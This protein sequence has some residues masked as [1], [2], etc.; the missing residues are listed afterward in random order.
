MSYIRAEDVLPP[1]VLAL[2]QTYI[3]G[4]MLY[5]PKKQSDRSNWGSVSGTKEYYA[6][7]NAEICA[8]AMCG[9]RVCE[10]ADQYGLTPKSIQRILRGSR[11]SCCTENTA[12]RKKP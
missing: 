10:L 6:E 9:V 7:R 11:P 12:E 3:D 8:K 5:I 4:K 1:D 2:V